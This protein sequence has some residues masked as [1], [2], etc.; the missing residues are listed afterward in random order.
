MTK[1]HT[2]HVVT[3]NGTTMAFAMLI[4]E[5]MSHD[6][7]T[8][9]MTPVPNIKIA[10]VSNG[11]YLLHTTLNFIPNHFDSKNIKFAHNSRPFT[12]YAKRHNL[13]NIMPGIF[14]RKA[15]D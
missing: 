12:V 9:D 3:T 5:S 4:G 11:A 10:N 7:R 8:W 13:K 14:C 6:I 1:T 2:M 15:M